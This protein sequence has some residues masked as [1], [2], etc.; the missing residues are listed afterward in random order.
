MGFCK[1][2]NLVFPRFRD[3]WTHWSENL[4][5][6]IHV[7][8]SNECWKLTRFPH[9]SFNADI[10]IIINFYIRESTYRHFEAITM[11]V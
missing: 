11:V 7:R 3:H 8:A 6:P 2:R 1:L 4:N 10:N 5:Y 9:T